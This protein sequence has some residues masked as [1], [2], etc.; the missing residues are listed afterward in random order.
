ML[1]DGALVAEAEIFFAHLDQARSRQLFGDRNFVFT[2]EM[3]Y[4]LGRLVEAGERPATGAA[5]VDGSKFMAASSRRAVITGVGVLSPIG[6][7][8]AAF[9]QSLHEGRSGIRPITAF[10][11]STLP[12]RFAGEIP[13]FD[14]KNY[15]DKK[16]RRSLKM[17]ARTIQL[18]VGAAQLALDRRRPSTRRSSI[19]SASA[20][21]SAPG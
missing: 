19:P 2:G 6:L 4:L 17:M 12:V 1:S 9:W 15:V 13:D 20:S 5:S 8:A 3:K 7:D 10:D 18:A 16:D 21:S 14:A 11:P